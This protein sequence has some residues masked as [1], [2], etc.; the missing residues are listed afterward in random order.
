MLYFPGRILTRQPLAWWM[1]S[2]TWTIV[3]GSGRPGWRMS[4]VISTAP[5]ETGSRKAPGVH[6]SLHASR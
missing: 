2:S 1:A 5:T 6:D 3:S 4:R